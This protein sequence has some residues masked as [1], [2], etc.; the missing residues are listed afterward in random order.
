[1]HQCDAEAG[2][3][4]FRK[5]NHLLTSWSFTYYYMLIYNCKGK[6]LWRLKYF[7]CHLC[8]VEQYKGKKYQRDQRLK[9]H[10]APAPSVIPVVPWA[11]L[12]FNS[13]KEH[14]EEA[15]SFHGGN[16]DYTAAWAAVAAAHFLL[17]I[18]GRTATTSWNK[19]MSSQ[20][21]YQATSNC[22]DH[23]RLWYKSFMLYYCSFFWSVTL[24]RT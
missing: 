4:P 14:G 3:T 22:S 5:K 15:G 9:S 21:Q 20:G 24:W 6:F 16:W 19:V 11:C 1:M 8:S 23:D 13:A 18:T 10:S 12:N 17:L 7:L 2:H